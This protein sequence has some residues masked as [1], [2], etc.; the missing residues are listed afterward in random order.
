MISFLEFRN[1]FELYDFI[2]ISNF[3]GIQVFSFNTNHLKQIHLL[4]YFDLYNFTHLIPYRPFHPYPLLMLKIFS[5]NDVTQ[6]GAF[7]LFL[8]FS[9]YWRSQNL[10]LHSSSF[11]DILS[12]LKANQLNSLLGHFHIPFGN[13]NYPIHD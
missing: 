5:C 2:F 12:E 8:S 1:S 3:Y 4:A 10:Y 11:L 9:Y 6:G 7:C 13:W